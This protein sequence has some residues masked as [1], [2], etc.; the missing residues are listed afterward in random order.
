[1]STSGNV[2][3]QK[4][5]YAIL[6]GTRNFICLTYIK[7][8]IFFYLEYN[9]LVCLVMEVGYISFSFHLFKVKFRETLLSY[10]IYQFFHFDARSRSTRKRLAPFLL[11]KINNVN[12]HMAFCDVRKLFKDRSKATKCKVMFLTSNKIEDC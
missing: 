5:K 12:K 10:V 9:H 8:I 11:M 7:C 6:K 4:G 3:F 2:R 1:M